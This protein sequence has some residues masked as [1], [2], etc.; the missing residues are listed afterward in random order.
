VTVHWPSRPGSP[1]YAAVTKP[2]EVEFVMK[3]LVPLILASGLLTMA[4]CGSDGGQASGVRQVSAA[5]GAAIAGDPP[6]DLVILDV[7]TAEEF[8]EVRVEGATMLDFYRDDF[9]EQLAELDRDVPYLLYCRSGNRS[10]QARELMSSLGF[11]DVAEVE[12]G[13]I[14]WTG[15]SLPT[16]S[17]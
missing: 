8:A 1:G 15:E 17:G 6:D 13:M 4:A 9:A 10:G 16:V 11:T 5:D 3:R 7:R 14:S 12:G 2:D